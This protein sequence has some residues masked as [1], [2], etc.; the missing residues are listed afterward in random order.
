MPRPT[1]P[2]PP[3][4]PR[5]PPHLALDVI[6]RRA[7]RVQVDRLDGRRLVKAGTAHAVHGGAGGGGGRQGGGCQ[8]SV[9][10]LSLLWGRPR[11]H[12]GGHPFC[13]LAPP[14][15]AARQPP[16]RPCLIALPSLHD[17]ARPGAA[18]R[19]SLA[20]KERVFWGGGRAKARPPY[21]RATGL[22]EHITVLRRRP[23]ALLLARPGLR[24]GAP[25][26]AEQGR[27]AAGAFGVAHGAAGAHWMG[28]D[29]AA[30]GVARRPADAA[31]AADRW[32]GAPA[33][34]MR[35]RAGGGRDPQRGGGA[36]HGSHGP[37]PSAV[38]VA[39]PAP[40]PGRVQPALLVRVN[41]PTT[42]RPLGTREGPGNQQTA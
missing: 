14:Q 36:A 38:A 16:R 9:T 30:P 39:P 6:Q 15:G 33:G 17:Q 24:I 41:P 31:A 35:A 22:N 21:A 20:A 8:G 1:A 34:G 37:L 29:G 13:C 11:P 32:C 42:L 18:R 3:Q 5:P 10:T 23:R 7:Q 12:F 19:R 4:A 2:H 40:R 26:A 28:H 27:E 25:L